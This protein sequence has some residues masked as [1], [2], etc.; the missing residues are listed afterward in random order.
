M[1]THQIAEIS[2][3]YIAH[4]T[5]LSNALSILKS[6]F[7]HG[8]ETNATHNIEGYPHFYLEGSIPFANGWE[9]KYEVRLVFWTDLKREIIPHTDRF[10]EPSPNTLYDTTS[11]GETH[12]GVVLRPESQSLLRFV[13]LNPR[14]AFQLTRYQRGFLNRM[15]TDATA[16]RA[17]RVTGPDSIAMVRRPRKD[18]GWLSNIVNDFVKSADKNT[19]PYLHP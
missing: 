4:Y 19:A 1:Y 14:P 15:L 8:A 18:R 16:V 13:G 2:M 10:V 9:D 3:P 11:F 7:I 17:T 12:I 5:S 6:G